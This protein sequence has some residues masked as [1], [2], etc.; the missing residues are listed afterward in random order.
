MENSHYTTC[1]RTALLPFNQFSSVSIANH[2][3]NKKT[4]VQKVKGGT[5]YQRASLTEQPWSHCF[6]NEE[7]TCSL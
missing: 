7:S 5:S 3:G 6:P 4:V 2:T 1:W